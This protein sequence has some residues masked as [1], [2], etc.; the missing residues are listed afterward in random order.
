MKNNFCKRYYFA[1]FLLLLYPFFSVVYA[2]QY[3]N[4]N[5]N[6]CYGSDY[7]YYYQGQLITEIKNIQQDAY[8]PATKTIGGTQY[9]FYI[10]VK[11]IK[12]TYTSE[13]AIIQ[14]GVDTYTWHGKTYTKA[15][16]YQ[17]TT[18]Y[19]EDGCPKTIVVLALERLVKG[20]ICH[21]EPF[22]F[23]NMKGEVKTYTW[24]A[25]EDIY[26]KYYQFGNISVNYN[27]HVEVVKGV[28]S[29]S[30][31]K[32]GIKEGTSYTWFGKQYTEQG[33]YHDTIKNA[34]GCDSIGTL[35][36]GVCSNDPDT[37]YVHAAIFKGQS[38][39]YHGVNYTTN[40]LK[41]VK[42]TSEYGCDSV[43]TLHVEVLEIQPGYE[44]HSMCEG[45]SY[46]WHGQHITTSG[47]YTDGTS[48]LLVSVLP[49]PNVDAGKDVIISYGETASLHASGSDYYEWRAD[50]TLSSLT[51][52]NTDATPKVT[53]MYYVKS[54]SSMDNNLVTNGDFSA[55]NTGFTT[56][57]INTMSC[58]GQSCCGTYVIM[59]ST[60]ARGWSGDE[61]WQPKNQYDHTVGDATGAF[62]IWD[63]F[64]QAN[65]ILWQ[66]TVTVQPNTTYAFSA[67][68]ISLLSSFE[69][70]YTQ[71]QFF[72]NGVQLGAITEAPHKEGLWGQYYEIWQSGTNTSATLTIKNQNTNYE[73]NDFGLDDISFQP[74]GTCVGEDSVKVIINYD[75]HLYP[76]CNHQIKQRTAN[77]AGMTNRTVTFQVDDC[78]NKTGKYVDGDQITVYVHDDGC[79]SFDQWSD[80]STDNPR[81]FTVEGSNFSVHPL[82]H[83]AETTV[84]IR[85]NQTGAGLV[86]GGIKTTPVTKRRR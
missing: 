15:G 58:S 2:Q 50:P 11:C 48:V 14:E 5:E 27:E 56:D 85:V 36:L 26:I 19:S 31:T 66:E 41:E 6:A 21:G 33:I 22:T 80:G 3:I 17:D 35:T 45:D 51:S 70:G 83:P 29:S 65:K 68:F 44:S 34:V 46:D 78:T 20:A 4:V 7:Q 55:G 52:A 74:I 12:P 54:H 13:T 32:I 30:K 10:N 62:M 38:F 28:E 61:P 79:T 84:L 23:T 77:V 18:S 69:Y 67:W 9:T 72:V 39:F 43:V 71:F 59:P 75:V 24:P 49:T 16:I 25:K 1:F 86:G 53:T 42:F 8:T 60:D 73:G 57:G 64:K 40:T 63:G 81:V 47:R 82:F 37:G 76:N